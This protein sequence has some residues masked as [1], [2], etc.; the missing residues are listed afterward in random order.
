MTV[1]FAAGVFAFAPGELFDFDPAPGAI[2]PAHGV[3]QENREIPKG[4]ELEKTRA[5][6]LVVSWGRFATTRAA[7]FAVGARH[8]IDDDVIGLILPFR[9]GNFP[10]NKLFE[11]VDFIEYGFNY[12]RSSSSLG[13]L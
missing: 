5:R 10:V 13:S 3:G 11:R 7:R 1:G 12:D 8:D 9:E 4:N 2:H 6:K